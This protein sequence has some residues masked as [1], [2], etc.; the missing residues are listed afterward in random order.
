[1]AEIRTLNSQMPHWETPVR[2]YL[3]PSPSTSP[4]GY[5]IVGVERESP[6]ESTFPMN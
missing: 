5:E 2:V 6:P 3:R 1:M 4:S